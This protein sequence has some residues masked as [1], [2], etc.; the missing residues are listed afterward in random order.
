[1]YHIE[2]GR[3]EYFDIATRRRG[4]RVKICGCIYHFESTFSP[5]YSPHPPFPNPRACAEYGASKTAFSYP[6]SIDNKARYCA[7]HQYDL[8][9]DVHT[10]G[11][12][13]RDSSG[14]DEEG[15][16][17]AAAAAAVSGGSGVK[18]EWRLVPRSSRFRKLQLIRE[19]WDAYDWLVW[20]D[21]DAL[22]VDPHTDV[23]DL[24]DK[25]PPKPP[26]T[27]ST[28]SCNV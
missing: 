21:L 18:A 27:C 6:F 20:M 19:M 8:N 12:A 7:L 5:H 23:L 10:G 11:L 13:V 1:M 28:C 25:V 14:E 15:D 16:E 22:F 26:P 17:A 4:E 3:G 9:V 24:L 2:L